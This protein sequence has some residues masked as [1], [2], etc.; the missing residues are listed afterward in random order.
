[1]RISPARDVRKDDWLEAKCRLIE[2]AG[3]DLRKTVGEINDRLDCLT[4]GGLGR[5]RLITE[6]H[7]RTIGQSYDTLHQV[8]VDVQDA[9]FDT[10]TEI[11]DLQERDVDPAELL[12]DGE[13]LIRHYRFLRRRARVIDGLL[14]F[15]PLVASSARS[16]LDHVKQLREGGQL[17]APMV[18]PDCTFA[19][20]ALDELAEAR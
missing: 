5:R 13:R 3:S 15:L 8:L 18:V 19:L 6:G 1:M 2:R 9:L 4:D 12:V 10:E 16:C 20:A 11:R 17:I 14:A 7:L